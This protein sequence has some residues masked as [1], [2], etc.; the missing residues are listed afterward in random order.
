MQHSEKNKPAQVKDRLFRR[1]FSEQ[2]LYRDIFKDRPEYSLTPLE[3]TGII[4][5]LMLT[6]DIY[7]FDYLKDQVLQSIQ[8]L[9]ERFEPGMSHEGASQLRQCIYAQTGLY[10]LLSWLYAYGPAADR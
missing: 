8:F 7:G 9:S 4:G 2:S 10:E 3:K 5:R 1:Y 6:E